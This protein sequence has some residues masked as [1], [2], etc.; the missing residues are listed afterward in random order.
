MYDEVVIGLKI[1]GWVTKLFLITK[2]LTQTWTLSPC[3][4]S[5]VITYVAYWGKAPLCMLLLDDIGLAGENKEVTIKVPATAPKLWSSGE[6][7]GYYIYIL[8]RSSRS[9]ALF[10]GWH[11]GFCT[12]VFLFLNLFFLMCVWWELSPVWSDTMIKSLSLHQN[13]EI[14]VSYVAYSGKAMLCVLLLDDNGLGGETKE[15][16][17]KVPATTLELWSSGEGEL[18]IFIF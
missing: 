15:V 3:L 8:T 18:I 14:V 11:V 10:T 4:F 16:T 6:G 13:S 7:W 5:F 17:I 2:G 9:N 12:T 1:I